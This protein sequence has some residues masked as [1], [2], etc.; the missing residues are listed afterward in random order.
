MQESASGIPTPEKEAELGSYKLPDG[1]LCMPAASVRNAL[2]K[3]AGNKSGKSAIDGRKRKI[4]P[5]LAGAVLFADEYFP[6]VDEG[7]NPIRE[8][9]LDI[10]SVRNPSTSGRIPRVRPR[11]DPPWYLVCTFNYKSVVDLD[12]IKVLLNEAGQT[13]GIGDFRIEKKGPFGGFE[14]TEV[15]VK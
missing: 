7:G 10:R 13:V 14:V 6:L 9:R 5:L 2:L 8:Y 11:I 12:L 1:S 3:A 4:G 15:D